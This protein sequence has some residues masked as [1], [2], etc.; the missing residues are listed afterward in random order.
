MKSSTVT[1]SQECQIPVIGSLPYLNK[2]FPPK[3][4]TTQEDTI[5]LITARVCAPAD[6]K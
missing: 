3:V 6:K 5:F 1:T 2:L 4:C